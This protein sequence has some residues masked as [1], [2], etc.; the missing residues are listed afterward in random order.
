MAY[1]TLVYVCSILD[2]VV[3]VHFSDNGDDVDVIGIEILLILIESTY[4]ALISLLVSYFG[5]A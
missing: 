3:V 1:Q 2:K 4:R 5:E